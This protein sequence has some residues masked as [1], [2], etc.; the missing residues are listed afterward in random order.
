VSLAGKVALVTGGAGGIGRGVADQLLR[1]GVLVAIASRDATRLKA[2]V[3]GLAPLGR[4]SA[5]SCDVTDAAAVER[6][7]AEVERALGALDVLVCAHGVIGER[8]TVLDASAEA[9]RRTLEINLVGTFLCGQAAARAMVSGRRRGR[10]INISSITA[11]GAAPQ[12]SAYNSSKGGVDA[13]TRSM[14]VDLAGHEI[15]VNAIAPG[16]VS[17]PMVDGVPAADPSINPLGRAGEPTEIGRAVVWLAD[18]A[19]SFVTGAT[20]VMDGGRRAQV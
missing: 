2:A 18:P 5:H 9:W 17:T 14:A 20:L 7:V 10:I 19:S 11:Q 13:L 8:C 1:A 12:L 6:L 16:R 15:T 4:V 3:A